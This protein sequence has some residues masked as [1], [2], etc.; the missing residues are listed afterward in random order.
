MIYGYK[1][2][3]YAASHNR[4]NMPY[5]GIKFTRGVQVVIVSCQTSIFQSFGLFFIQ[6]SQSTTYL[7]THRA[8]QQQ[9]K[10][11]GYYMPIDFMLSLFFPSYRMTLTWSKILL[12]LDLRPAKS[13]QAAPIQN[14]RPKKN[15]ISLISTDDCNITLCY[16][17]L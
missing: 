15:L 14:L 17:H 11:L 2:A 13:L 3:K 10:K 1:H 6:H 4:T 9:K 5:L 12:K 16:R 8:T 7:H